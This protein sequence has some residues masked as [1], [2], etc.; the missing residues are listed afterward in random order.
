MTPDPRRQA[1][2]AAAKAMFERI[3]SRLWS[4]TPDH[5]R[6]PWI[7]AAQKAIDAYEAAM[8]RPISEAPKDHTLVLVWDGREVTEDFYAPRDP[9]TASG[10]E[11]GHRISVTHFQP[12]PRPPSAPRGLF[13][14]LT[15]EQQA[16]ALSYDGPEAHGDPAFLLPTP[17]QDPE[18]KP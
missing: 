12:M 6:L 15:T 1:I 2:E 4:G 8:W 18:T 9:W 13:A 14:Q 3:E 17:P 7:I 16:A 11:H 10:D 5:T